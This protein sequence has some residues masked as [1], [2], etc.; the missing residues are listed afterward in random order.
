MLPAR[1]GRLRCLPRKDPAAAFA[2]PGDL[3][4]RLVVRNSTPK[5]AAIQRQVA[6]AVQRVPD[7]A[8]KRGPG[9]PDRIREQPLALIVRA[10][11]TCDAGE[12]VQSR[13]SSRVVSD[14]FEQFQGVAMNADSHFQICTL[15]CD[16]AEAVEQKGHPLRVPELTVES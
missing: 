13:R 12:Q 5:V 1:P 8:R 4:A 3:Q 7:Q 16:P 2:C 6:E 9:Q 11:I 14:R 10:L 15:A